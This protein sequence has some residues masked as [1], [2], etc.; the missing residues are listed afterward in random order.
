GEILNDRGK[1]KQHWSAFDKAFWRDA[2]DPNIRL[3]RVT[4]DKAEYWE[5]AGAVATVVKMIAAGLAGKKPVLG[6]NEKIAF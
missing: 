4:P 5:R 6:D 2:D 3:L 1:I